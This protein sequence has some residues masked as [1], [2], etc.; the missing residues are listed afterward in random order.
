MK[1]LD[2][3]FDNGTP[4]NRIAYDFYRIN[5]HNLLCHIAVLIHNDR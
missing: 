2:Q 1:L 4:K 3:I 5:R